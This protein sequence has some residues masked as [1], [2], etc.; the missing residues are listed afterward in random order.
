MSWSRLALLPVLAALLWFAGMHLQRPPPLQ[1]PTLCM[2]VLD[3][4]QGDSLL[5][6]FSG[7][8]HWLVDGG[9][10]PGGR[11]D[12][13][14]RKLLPMLRRLGVERLDK[15]FVTHAHADHFE[16]LFA[17]LES[18]D[19]DELWLPYRQNL[20]PRIRA[21]VQLA[22]RRGLRVREASSGA[23]PGPSP[24][25]IE[26]QIL[27]PWPGASSALGSGGSE[28]NNR[29]LVL[30]LALGKVSF[31][32]TGDIEAEAE[33][34]LIKGGVRLRS[35]VLKV[36]HHA[37]N[38]SSTPG[39]VE[40]VDPMVALAGIGADNRFGFPHA[41]VA[42]RYLGRGTPLYWT[43]RH[44]PM[45]LCTGGYSLRLEA[46]SER[47]APSTLR[48]WDAEALARWS[49][50]GEESTEQTPPQRQSACPTV[51]SKR[52]SSR[53]GKKSRASQ[54]KENKR[55]N[56]VQASRARKEKKEAAAVNKQ[57]RAEEREW[58]RRRKA[59]KRLRAP[60]R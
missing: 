31:L 42:S 3:V 17:V 51:A 37:S 6:S 20:G 8:R 23:Q 22:S 39:F 7:R 46:L 56:R 19:C 27:Y 4:G 14:R 49:R 1:R 13:G 26:S 28:A 59:R 2:T 24:A 9:G 16:G 57:R 50:E 36:P 12:V 34:L 5:L 38:T 47:G 40:R 25:P 15:V 54:A 55:S 11:Y 52:R 48:S 10:V 58:Q 29:S 41:S 53:G 43:G 45:R 33:D 35:T 44:G 21:L 60:W 30:R 32:L 18:I